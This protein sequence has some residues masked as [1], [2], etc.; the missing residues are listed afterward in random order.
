MKPEQQRIAI[1]EACG[2]QGVPCEQRWNVNSRDKT[3]YWR[4]VTPVEVM[5]ELKRDHFGCM[6]IARWLRMPNGKPFILQ[7]QPAGVI[8]HYMTYCDHAVTQGFS[9]S[10]W[11]KEAAYG[12]KFQTDPWPTV[13]P[14]LAPFIKHLPDYLNDLNAMQSAV[15]CLNRDTLDYSNY[16]SHLNQ[17][18]AIANS[19]S[20]SRPIQVC[21]ATAAQR[22][23]AF[24]KTLNLWK[25]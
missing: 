22:A 7:R 12:W 17:I 18:V 21:D 2:W 11:S 9:N 5:D 4:S 1:A 24:L 15:M 13:K 14:S 19:I 20:R 23:E 3:K 6:M 8:N 16:C 10:E 25:P